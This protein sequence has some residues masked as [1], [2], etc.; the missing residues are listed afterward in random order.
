V[1]ILTLFARELFGPLLPILPVDD[2]DE[3][4]RFVKAR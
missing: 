1:A 2:V 3:A 4:V